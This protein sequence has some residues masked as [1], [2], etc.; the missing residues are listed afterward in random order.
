M[1]SSDAIGPCRYDLCCLNIYVNKIKLNDHRS[2]IQ[3]YFIGTQ[4][5][6]LFA[7][8]SWNFILYLQYRKV[9]FSYN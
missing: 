2:H 8:I 9:I 1:Y 7:N 6:G 3:M 4:N 5:R